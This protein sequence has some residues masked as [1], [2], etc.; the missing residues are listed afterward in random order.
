MEGP[1]EKKA[2]SARGPEHQ[3]SGFTPEHGQYL[4][5]YYYTKINGRSRFEAICSGSLSEVPRPVHH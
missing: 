3:L 4:Y 1:V 5:L 2:I